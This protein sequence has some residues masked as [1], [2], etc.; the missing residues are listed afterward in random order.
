MKIPFLS[1]GPMHDPLK[2]QLT[3]AFEK[4]LDSNWFV[5]GKEVEDFEKQ[6]AAYNKV[7]HAVG[8]SNGLDAIHI[9]LKALGVGP[10]DEVIVPSNTYI[11]TLLAVSYVGAM[12]VLAEPDK[13][14][15]NIDPSA[16][17]SVITAKTKAII[18]VH[19]YGQICQMDAIM[20]I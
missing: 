7:A 1:F 13:R 19:L 20:Q 12:P 18:P 3:A 16:I 4:V 11:A 10:G 6:Y 17:E 9:A 2:K 14:T 8:V 15:Y 5:L